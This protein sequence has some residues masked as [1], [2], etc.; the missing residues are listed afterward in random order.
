MAIA[1]FQRT[2]MRSELNRLIQELTGMTAE[3]YALIAQALCN[4]SDSIHFAQADA[5]IAIKTIHI[6]LKRT[7]RVTFLDDSEIIIDVP[8]FTPRKK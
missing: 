8:P 3:R 4:M 1:I 7:M 6:G 2:D 5:I